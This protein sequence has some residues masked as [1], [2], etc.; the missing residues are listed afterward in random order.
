[1]K[2][3]F[4]YL[5]VILLG[6][7][8]VFGSC[9][10]DDDPPTTDP[11]V[12]PGTSS[13][14]LLVKKFTAAPDMDGSTLD[15][16]WGTAQTLVGETEVPNLD[17]RDTWLNPDGEGVE[18]TFGLFAPYNGEKN[19]FKLRAGYYDNMIYLRLEWE[20]DA[21]SKDRQS[22]YFD[23]DDKL[24]KGEHKY[25]NN[26]NDKYYED[27]FAFLFPI[28]E[29]DNFTTST[30]YATCHGPSLPVATEMDKHT[31]HYLKSNGQ[32]V[33]MWH[34]KRVRGTYLGQ[35]DDQQMTYKDPPYNS[36]TNGRTGDAGDAGYS[37]NSQ[38]IPISGTTDTISVP[39]Y[40]VP[41]G[42]D[43]YWISIDDFGG[44]AKMVTAVDENGVL[45]LDGGIEIDP[46][47]GGYEQGD[48]LKRIPSVTTKA[49]TE[50]RAD[51]NISAV[52]TGTG[53]V[54]EFSRKLDTGHDDDVV[55]K[56]DEELAFG[57]AIFDNAAIAHGIKPGL[58]LKFEQ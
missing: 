56:V 33:D 14:E 52:Y 49:F 7:L 53:W 12:D 19:A 21:D 23:P 51:I 39:L 9:N 31:R 27:K 54:C 50:S 42:T 43:Y 16:M 40:V 48:G 20:D 34:W 26:D 2:K 11:P 36:G 32:L 3:Y 10:K 24:W 58:L 5:S 15:D 1:M 41:N 13:S 46:S 47:D 45:T 55:F 17:P 57:L 37:N 44:T 30:C 18:E 29:V 4:S 22:W 8:L 38:K 6:G 28:G 25:A 35:V